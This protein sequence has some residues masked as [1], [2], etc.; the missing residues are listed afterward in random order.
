M[1]HNDTEAIIIVHSKINFKEF[2]TPATPVA[3]IIK[4][5]FQK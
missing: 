3:Y 1:K 2:W 4:I 5:K